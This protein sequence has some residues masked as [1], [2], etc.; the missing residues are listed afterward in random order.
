MEN[1]SKVELTKRIRQS[2]FNEG[3]DISGI[4]RVE[5]HPEDVDHISGWVNNGR[6]GS[7]H[8]IE[9]NT[10]KRG[11][12]STLVEGA[13]SII[14]AGLRYYSN[15]AAAGNED[16][17]VA[18]YA[19]VRDYH[20]VVKEKLGR[21]LDVLKKEA[22]GAEGRIFCDSAPVTEKTWAIRAG[23]GWRGRNSLVINENIGSFFFLGEIVTSVEL[24]YESA[25]TADHC[26]SCTICIDSCPTG[27]IC[28]DRTIDA[29]RCIAYLT[30]E[31]KGDIPPDFEGKMENIIFGCDRCQEV[32]P[33]N[34]RSVPYSDK[35]LKPDY[36]VTQLTKSDWQTMTEES[37]NKIFRSSPVRRTGLEKMRRN[38]CLV[39]NISPEKG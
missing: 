32:C 21:V 8:F 27:A 1:S 9:E 35:E 11:D 15:E 24:V 2:L 4:T 22:P 31:H 12:L 39:T 37:F 19:R 33:W 13:K 6:N 23:L 34:K 28:S 25:E 26:G 30:I 38:I 14:V 17:F 7:M 3:F 5:K 10:G 20:T 29:R 18:R 16:Y 36:N